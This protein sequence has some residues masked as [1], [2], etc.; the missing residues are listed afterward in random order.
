[1]LMSSNLQRVLIPLA[2]TWLSCLGR[3]DASP[4][5]VA[6]TAERPQGIL[7]IVTRRHNSRSRASSRPDS[8]PTHKRTEPGGADKAAT[9]YCAF[10]DKGPAPPISRPRHGQSVSCTCLGG[11]VGRARIWIQTT[12]RLRSQVGY[13]YGATCI[14]W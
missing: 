14:S 6:W 1:M 12:P 9:P 11:C 4:S 5:Q 7:T 2:G 8:I 3:A 13:R 10:S